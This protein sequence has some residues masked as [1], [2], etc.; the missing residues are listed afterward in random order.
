MLRAVGMPDLHPGK[1]SPVGA[2]FLSEGVVYPALVGNDIG[3]GMGLW[4]LDVPARKTQLDKW[5]KRLRG[6]EQPW[7]GDAAEWLAAHDATPCGFEDALGTI[8]G[9]NHF[10]ELQR[11]ERV[12]DESEL[13][14]LDLDTSAVLLLVHSG[15]RGLGESVLQTHLAAHGHAGVD[16]DGD[17]GQAYLRAHD[18]AVR[19]AMANRALI[20]HRMGGLIGAPGTRVLDAC[21]N[22][23][24]AQEVDGRRCWLHR[25]GATPATVGPVVIPG[26]RGAWSYLVVPVLPLDQPDRG[27]F[28]LAHGAGRKFS[29]SEMKGRLRERFSLDQLTRTELGSRVICE[30]RDL[31]YEEAPQAYKNV[32]VV[33]QDLVDAGL[34]RVAAVL[35]PLLTYKTRARERE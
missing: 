7:D 12:L 22:H 14:R 16:A 1:G 21:H 9:G 27:L 20:A 19:W 32:D 18:R 24:E 5:E 34:A 13:A 28:S 33:V 26:S 2:A 11:V 4:T 3:C 29:R 31:L 23:V 15:S 10:A 35:R 30:D 25:K 8:G 17:G 6:L